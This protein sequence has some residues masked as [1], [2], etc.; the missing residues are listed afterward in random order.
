MISSTTEKTNPV[1][2][3][4]PPPT[5]ASRVTADDGDSS[6]DVPH[7]RTTDS[8]TA[9][10]TWAATTAIRMPISGMTQ[11]APSHHSRSRIAR[12]LTC[13]SAAIR[14]RQ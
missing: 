14:H 4:M 12:E 7:R 13:T 9:S 5:A 6:A 8:S 11:N 2:V 10:T 1:K 3:T